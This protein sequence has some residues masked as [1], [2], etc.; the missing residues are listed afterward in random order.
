[1]H[2]YFVHGYALS[3]GASDQLLARVDYAGEIAAVFGRD[4]MVGTQFHP[5]K[6]QTTGLKFIE[7]FL[8]W[9]P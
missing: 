8:G 3:G 1:M 2:S 4:N 5:E 6:S 7:N 9:K